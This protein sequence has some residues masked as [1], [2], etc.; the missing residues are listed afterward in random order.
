MFF[1]NDG[2]DDI[3]YFYDINVKTKLFNINCKPEIQVYDQP[4]NI[5]KVKNGIYNKRMF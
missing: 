3:L 1:R 5:R 2:S 4:N